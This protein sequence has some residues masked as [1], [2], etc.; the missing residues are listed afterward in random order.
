M[1]ATTPED[2][3][4]ARL[5]RLVATA[6]AIDA[7]LGAILDALPL[8][9]AA[10]ADEMDDCLRPHSLAYYRRSMVE[11]ILAD[12]MKPLR[13]DLQRVAGMTAEELERLWKAEH[14]L[15]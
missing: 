7:E 8:E 13:E 3:A 12:D 6:E 5:Q 15:S 1:S 4:R 11:C 14:G 10:I 9:D 2:D